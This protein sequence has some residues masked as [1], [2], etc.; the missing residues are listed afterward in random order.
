MKLQMKPLLIAQEPGGKEDG[1]KED[2]GEGQPQT[3]L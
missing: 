1:V 3:I 2:G